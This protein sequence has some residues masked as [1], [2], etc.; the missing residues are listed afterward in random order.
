MMKHKKDRSDKQ[1]QKQALKKHTQSPKA[2]TTAASAD[3]GSKSPPNS[4]QKESKSAPSG[5]T[6]VGSEP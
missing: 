1:K 4:T 5:H 3:G 6:V 2:T